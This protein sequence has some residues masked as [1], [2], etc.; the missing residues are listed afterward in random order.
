MNTQINSSQ[1]HASGVRTNKNVI[2][3]LAIV[4]FISLLV[5]G[6]M[7][8]IYAGRFVPSTVNRLESATVSLA[9]IF[10]HKNNTSSSLSVVSNTNAT[11][12]FNNSTSTIKVGKNIFLPTHVQKTKKKVSHKVTPRQGTR[13]NSVY[14]I[15]TGSGTTPS[16]IFHG[17]PDLT[18]HITATGYLTSTSTKSFVATTTIPHNTRVAVRFTITNDGTNTTIPWTFSASIPTA[19]NYV[20]TSP[21]QQPLNPGDHIEYILGFDQATAG[22]DKMISITVDPSHSVTESNEKN[23][24]SATSVTILGQ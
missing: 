8:A 9:Q 22:N 20:F 5:A 24:N 23:N 11:I 10:Q 17:L 16:P 13:K 19:T 7:L 6:V 2:N 1:T 3:S 15:P 18:V 12:S 14:K 21:K 4:G